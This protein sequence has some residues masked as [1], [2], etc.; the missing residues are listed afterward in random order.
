M[1]YLSI[2]FR[3]T[4]T[5]GYPH[6]PPKEEDMVKQLIEIIKRIQV[7]EDKQFVDMQNLIQKMQENQLHHVSDQENAPYCRYCNHCHDESTCA[8]AKR[9][10]D[11]TEAGTSNQ[12]NHFDN[13]KE[14]D[15]HLVK[16]L[17][18]MIKDM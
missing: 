1:D 17:T 5:Q 10:F 6:D 13:E 12:I 8:I 15:K 7:K 9:I 11:S 14:N 2:P 3:C 18:Q 4:N 16:E